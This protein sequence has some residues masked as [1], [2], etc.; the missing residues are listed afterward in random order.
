MTRLRSQAFHPELRVPAR[1]LPGRVVSGPRSLG[2]L[3]RLSDLKRAHGVQVHSCGPCGVAVF[4]PAQGPCRGTVLWLHGGGMILGRGTD[5]AE[6]LQRMADELRAIVVSVDYRLAPEHPYPVPLEDCYAALCWAAALPEAAGLPV[7]VAGGSA[8]GGLAAG[9][10]LAA[11]DRGEVALAA[12]VLIYPMLDDRTACRPDPQP[13][14]RRLWDDVAN[15][16]AWQSYLAAAPGSS[17]IADYA[18]PARATTLSGL[19]PT[20]IGVGSLDLFHDEDVAYAERLW[21]AGVPCELVVVDGAFHGFDL[22]SR[23][24]VAREFR[25]SYVAAMDAALAGAARPQV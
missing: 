2:V 19:P 1:V 20:W 24:E 21:A 15:R 14:V 5:D 22:A 10:A 3:R 7:V 8:G 6:S 12:Q 16:F 13:D 4:R 17:Q 23:T 9:V 25:A 18:A 11:R